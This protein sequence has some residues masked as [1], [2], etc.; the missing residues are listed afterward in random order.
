MGLQRTSR[1]VSRLLCCVLVVFIA[2]V[3]AEETWGLIVDTSRFWY[4][5]RHSSN[6]LRLYGM[7]PWMLLAVLFVGCR[8]NNGC[9]LAV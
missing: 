3:G 9:I 8:E 7:G 4:N 2:V 1:L 5:Y 6:A